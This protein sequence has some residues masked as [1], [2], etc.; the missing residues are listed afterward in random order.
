M[1]SQV[2]M[3]KVVN[4]RPAGGQRHSELHQLFHQQ[5]THSKLSLATCL[6]LPQDHHPKPTLLL[7]LRLCLTLQ[8]SMKKL[9]REPS[10]SRAGHCQPTFLIGRTQSLQNGQKLHGNPLS[11]RRRINPTSLDPN[12]RQRQKSR[13]L[14]LMRW[15]SIRT[16]RRPR[17]RTLQPR[18]QEQHH[19]RPRKTSQEGQALCLQRLPTV[20]SSRI[21]LPHQV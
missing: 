5:G 16:H 7:A 12:I 20:L 17:T 6:R 11:R 21:H 14:S 1:C 10:R 13:L 18:D 8:S 2:P 4:R 3:L 19:L 15:I 9:G